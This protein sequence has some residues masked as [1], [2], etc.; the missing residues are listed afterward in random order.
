MQEWMIRSNASQ[1]VTR[2]RDKG[3]VLMYSGKVALRFTL[4]IKAAPAAR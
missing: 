2:S 1:R 4:G 3:V